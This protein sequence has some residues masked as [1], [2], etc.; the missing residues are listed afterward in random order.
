MGD[1]FIVK[2]SDKV[3]LVCTNLNSKFPAAFSSLDLALEFIVD[4]FIKLKNRKNISSSSTHS[5]SIWLTFYDSVSMDVCT[6]DACK[7]STFHGHDILD[8]VNGHPNL[9]AKLKLADCDN[10]SIIPGGIS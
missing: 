1:V 8:I 4:V 2:S 5:F 9:I 6:L 3:D 7:S 10:T